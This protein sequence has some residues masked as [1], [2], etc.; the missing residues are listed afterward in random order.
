MLFSSCFATSVDE[1][2]TEK[3]ITEMQ[4]KIDAIGFNI[5]NSNGIER[6][7]VFDIDVKRVKN[8][9]STTRDRQIVVY[10]GMMDRLNSDDEIASV[11][12]HE[13]SHSVDSY[14]GIFKGYFSGFSYFLTP[15]KF[16][17]KADKRAI[18]YMVNANYNPVAMIVMMSRLMPE[19]RYEW[20][21]T[22]PTTTNRM[23]RVYE[24][25]YKKYPQYLVNNTYKTNPYYQNFLLVTKSQRQKFASKNQGRNL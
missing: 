7:T 5:L 17:Y 9:Y 6:R 14:D 8:A 3:K 18:D 13:I 15:R 22:H 11:L 20:C 25:I 23:M 2:I 19:T 16:E 12:A 21:H 4:N 1:V 10:R 24:Y